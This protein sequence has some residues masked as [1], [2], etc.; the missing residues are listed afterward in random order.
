ML[1]KRFLLVGMTLVAVCA[2]LTSCSKKDL[3]DPTKPEEDAKALYE[4]AF[5]DYIGGPVNPRQDWGFNATRRAATRF[6]GTG[7]YL[8]ESF[9]KEYTKDFYDTALDSLPEGKR[10]GESIKNFEFVSRGP[11][12]FD[13]I[14][15]YTEEEV[16]IGYYYYNPETQSPTDRKEVRLVGN[17]IDDLASNNYF[18]YTIYSQ[19][20][21]TQ[22]DTPTAWR[23]YNIWTS[24]G[25]KMVRARMFTLR[26]EDVPVGY[27]VGFYVKNPKDAGETTYTN[28]Y[29]NKDEKPFF[30]VLDAKSGALENAYVVGMEDRASAATCDDFDCNDVMLAV[31]KNVET[32]FPLLYIPEKPVEPKEPGCRI[33]AEDLNVHDLNSDGKLEE[34]DFDFNDIVLDVQLTADGADCVLQAAGAT[35]EI[36]I[37][38]DPALEVHKLFGVNQQVMVNTRAEK[39]GLKGAAKP[40]VK[41]SIK[42]N[43]K[44]AS[45]I[46]IKV[47]KGNSWIELTA[48]PG[49]AA[50]KI[51]V[52]TDFEWT[53]ERESLK[54]KYPDFPSYARDYTNVDTWWK[55]VS[56]N[57]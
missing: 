38:D 42:G 8:S 5:L 26:V 16:E 31:H 54:K 22:W 35:L 55:N 7:Y 53:D 40:P 12:R 2:A 32:T 14:F 49:R 39:S 15:S 45:D 11:F 37:N 9:D 33:I 18:Q 56:A 24:Y 50:S 48:P 30:A 51:A 43:F 36:M 57:R 27:R 28:K 34:T 6:E 46:P 3:Y 21:E 17:I 25:A 23:G 13:M 44:S 41:F 19:P 52:G 47:F 1:M 29:L 20:S 10:V 4:K